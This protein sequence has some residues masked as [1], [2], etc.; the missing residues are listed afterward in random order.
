MLPPIEIAPNPKRGLRVLR[1]EGNNT[2]GVDP[3]KMLSDALR[4]RGRSFTSAPAGLAKALQLD[5]LR[6]VKDLI[7]VGMSLAAE[8]IFRYCR[9]ET[10]K[11]YRFRGIFNDMPIDGMLAEHR[12]GP[13][14]QAQDFA[15]TNR[16]DIVYC[17]LPSSR[18]REIR[19][20]MEF[21][22][23]NTIRFRM[24]PSADSF[25]P[26][27]GSSELDF[28]G[29]VPV[30]KMRSEPLERLTNRWIKRT[31][32]IIFSIAVIVFVFS[33]LFPILA[34]LVKASSKG[35]VFYK[36]LRAGKDN[37]PFV[38]WKFRSM[39]VSLTDEFKQATKSDDRVTRMGAFLRRTSLDEMPQFFNVL[40][41]QM[42]VVGP[43]PHPIQLNEQYRDI[44]DKYMVRYFVRPGITGW[45]QV[46]GFRGETRTPDLMEKRVELDV[47]Y[48][49]NWSFWL[50]LRIVM[51]TVLNLTSKEEAAY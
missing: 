20:L 8:D 48:L 33:W 43:R 14:Q 3:T 44:V 12:V 26:F 2:D 7:I 32:D 39:R 28:H 30:S 27:S 36:Q 1:N 15:L 4:R 10:V 9:E 31:F 42:S 35:P 17:A 19:E 47:K 37:K 11:G 45:A 21:C 40:V 24:I 29:N 38:C 34:L 18:A 5:T 23:S 46:N 49:E 51:R 25:L 13:V 22:E 16:I 41:G 50:D 6:P